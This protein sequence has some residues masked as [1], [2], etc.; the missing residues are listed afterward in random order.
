MPDRLVAVELHLDE[1]I[2][3]QIVHGV[4][5]HFAIDVNLLEA[6]RVHEMERVAVA[7]E[8][9]HL[10]LVENRALHVLFRAEL[11]VRQRVGSDIAKPA[12]DESALVARRH[13]L[14]IEDA[15][16]IV[17]DPDEIA[18]AETRGLN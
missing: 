10:V 5:E 6:R 16:Q 7:V 14:K 12:L 2:G 8:I 18:F 4:A 1:R 13:V 3:K 17:A 11:H 15:Q 9:L